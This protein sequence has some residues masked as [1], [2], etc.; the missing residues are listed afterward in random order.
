[1][2]KNFHDVSFFLIRFPQLGQMFL[3]SN[4]LFVFKAQELQPMVYLEVEKLIFFDATQLQGHP[5]INVLSTDGNKVEDRLAKL[6]ENA[7][8]FVSFSCLREIS[9]NHR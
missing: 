8:L 3:R 2:K 6:I 1:M 4:L 7:I 9:G 5:N